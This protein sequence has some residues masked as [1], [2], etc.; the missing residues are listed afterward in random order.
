MTVKALN[1]PQNAPVAP[2][3]RPFSSGTESVAI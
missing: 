2:C 3:E 1:S